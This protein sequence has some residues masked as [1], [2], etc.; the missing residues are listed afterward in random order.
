MTREEKRENDRRRVFSR[1]C[2]GCAARFSVA[3]EKNPRTFCTKPCGDRY[4]W[5]ASK[6]PPRC[7]SCGKATRIHVAACLACELKNKK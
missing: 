1:T 6:T 4:R 7:A 5:H 2:P 3:G